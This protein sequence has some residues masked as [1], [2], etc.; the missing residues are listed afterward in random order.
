MKNEFKNIECQPLYSASYIAQGVNDI[1]FFS[2]KQD[3]LKE[4]TSMRNKAKA[5]F[6][7]NHKNFAIVQFYDYAKKEA[8][9]F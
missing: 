3:A 2:S 4:A 7:E 8:I 5:Q 6:G 9:D 1:R